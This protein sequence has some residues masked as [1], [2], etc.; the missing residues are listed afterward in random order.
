MSHDASI[1][2]VCLV[3]ILAAAYMFRKIYAL[4]SVSSPSDLVLA[5]ERY[6]LI[7]DLFTTSTTLTAQLLAVVLGI[8]TLLRGTGKVAFITGGLT[9]AVA[10]VGGGCPSLVQ[11]I[12]EFVQKRYFP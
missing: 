5:Q 8:F 2:Y 6:Q 3:A 7:R 11:Y 1:D 4:A 9:L 10:A 12:F